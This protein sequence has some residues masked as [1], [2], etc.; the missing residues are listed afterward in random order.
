MSVHDRTIMRITETFRNRTALFGLL[1]LAVLT[2][3]VAVALYFRGD[4]KAEWRGL[5][6][7]ASAVAD[8]GQYADATEI[9]EKTVAL[10]EEAF[11]SD[12]PNLAA[13]LTNLALLKRRLG[14]YFEAESHYQR[15][16]EISQ[17]AFGPSHALVVSIR[18][19]LAA[20]YKEQGKYIAATSV[21]RVALSV[22]EGIYG[23]EDPNVLSALNALAGAYFLQ[24]AND[25]AELLYPESTEGHRWTA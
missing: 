25:D 12:H 8:E 3:T 23:S 16:L 22:A 19:S 18:R 6:A 17:G 5:M 2:A 24:G 20:T 9:A 10:A 4:Q 15:A 13:S 11:G 7:Q 1:G 21:Y 14:Q